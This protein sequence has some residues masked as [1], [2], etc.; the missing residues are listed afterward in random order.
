MKKNISLIISLLVVFS[1]SVSPN[2]M[3]SAQPE[4]TN[5]ST[6]PDGEAPPSC[7][8]L[9]VIFVVDQSGSMSDSIYATD[10]TG[11][12]ETAVEAMV[13]W[14]SEWESSLLAPRRGWI[15]H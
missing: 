5:N 1:M 15:S 6:N 14:L 11:Q 12:R 8:P 7:Y 2:N 3:P 9:D 13:D 10:P 4:N